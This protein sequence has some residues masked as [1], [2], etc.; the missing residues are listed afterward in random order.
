MPKIFSTDKKQMLHELLKENC[1]NLMKDSGYKG[2]NIRDLAKTTGISAGTFYNFYHSKEALILE[3]MNDC[4]NRMQNQF[5]EIY[6]NKGGVSRT[7]FIDLYYDFFMTDKNNVLQYL[8]RD[9][10]TALLLRSDKK[11]TLE[12]AKNIILQ[13]INLLSNPREHINLNAVINFTQLINLCIEN[14]DLLVEEELTST[15][16]KLLDNLADELFQEAANELS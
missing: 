15:I 11:I 4:Q 8:S 6:Q 13:N 2:L 16:E 10:L 3:I 9:D 14:K 5:L 1:V 7:D 12:T